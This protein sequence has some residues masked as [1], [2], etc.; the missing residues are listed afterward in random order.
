MPLEWT[1][2]DD[3]VARLG[4]K[5][6]KRVLENSGQ[7]SSVR[8]GLTGSGQTPNYQVEVEGRPRALFSGRSHKDW[9]RAVDV[10][11][12]HNISEP[13]AYADL[14]AAF[15]EQY[16]ERLKGKSLFGR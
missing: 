14:Y 15:V 12:P 8:F 1:D 5:F 11:E 16:R 7:A 10:F 4:E 6:M 9:T 3:V 13:F 2:A